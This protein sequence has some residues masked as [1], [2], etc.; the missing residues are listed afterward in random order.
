VQTPIYDI[1]LIYYPTDEEHRYVKLILEFL[2]LQMSAFSLVRG[3][4]FRLGYQTNRKQWMLSG[5]LAFGIEDFDRRHVFTMDERWKLSY[6]LEKR[7]K[8][9]LKWNVRIDSV[10]KSFQG[11]VTI[12]DPNDQLSTPI[13]SDVQG[14]LTDRMIIASL[15]TSYSSLENQSQSILVQLNIDQRL[16]RQQYITVNIIH[17]SSATNLSLTID[18]YPQRQLRI[19]YSFLL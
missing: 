14:Q 5:N 11:R 9:Y 17:Q 6:G 13:S 3:R 19:N 8:I 16:L 12:Q 4:S 1:N 15:R 7:E 2:P 10:M 18:H